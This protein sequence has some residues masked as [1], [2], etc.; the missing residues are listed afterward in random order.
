MLN[1]NR[2]ALLAMLIGSTLNAS[3]QTDA[4]PVDS[5][6]IEEKAPLSRRESFALKTRSCLSSA[7]E[8][9]QN[10]H[11]F[12]ANHQG[13]AAA[14]LITATVFAVLIAQKSHDVSAQELREAVEHVIA[15]YKESLK[16]HVR[17]LVNELAG[18]VRNLSNEHLAPL[19]TSF[20]KHTQTLAQNFAAVDLVALEAAVHEYNRVA[21]TGN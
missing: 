16:G 7:K 15:G 5:I 9:M 8:K 20:L 21:C 11:S 17:S 19:Y 13:V 12:V 2:I 18:T 4:N 10:L 14:T 6:A 1:L 3:T